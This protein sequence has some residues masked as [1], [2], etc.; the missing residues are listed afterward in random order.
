MKKISK[1]GATFLL[2]VFCLT[3]PACSGMGKEKGMMEKEKVMG[4]E[5]SMTQ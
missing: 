2:A 1:I 5:K 3:L 4:E